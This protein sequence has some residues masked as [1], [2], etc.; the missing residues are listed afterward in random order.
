MRL[1]PQ[2]PEIP[3]VGGFTAENDLFSYRDFADKLTNLVQNIEEPLV[4][5]L[6]GPWGSGKSVFVKQW[7]GLLRERGGHAI[8]FNAFENDHYED[9]FLALSAEVHATAKKTLGGNERT[10]RSYLNKAK[11]AGGVLAPIAL[12][13]AARAATAGILSLEDVEAGNDALKAAA[14]A[15][16]NEAA[17]T[18]EKVVSE[19]L[20]KASDERAALEAFR[21]ALSAVAGTLAKRQAGERKSY[22][23]V[24]IV[25]EL[26]RCRPPF[27]LNVIERIKHMFSVP[28]VC[29]VLVTHLPQ[30]EQAVQ[31][32]YGASFDAAIYLEKFYQLRVVL[33]DAENQQR[34]HRTVYVEYLWNALGITFSEARSG[35][36]VQRDIQILADT[37]SLSL[38]RLER[39]ITH[40]A[41]V[42]AAAGPGHLIV[43][44]IVAGL[45]VM[46]QTHPE[47]YAKA[48][49]MELSWHEANGFLSPPEGQGVQEEWTLNWWK[50]ATGEELSDEWK[51]QFSQGLTRYHLHTPQNLMRFTAQF[52]DDLT[53]RG[54]HPEER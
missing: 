30:L 7:A 18:V 21:V 17:K 35:E 54:N 29:F 41:L 12:R 44:P 53:Q 11:R 39:V 40:V 1:T 43:P 9:A 20:R 15:L 48:R 50:F 45:C 46:R 34:N 23:L 47:L 16:G 8:H 24:V 51:R 6:D 4:I 2:E 25:D 38:R 5:T 52:I 26:D 27:A 36:L 3:E 32:A 13:V 49:R 33:P 42:C 10:T 28:G 14:K 19:R 22:P 37:Y 31:G